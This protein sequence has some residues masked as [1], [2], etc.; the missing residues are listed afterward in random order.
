M[1]TRYRFILFIVLWVMLLTPACEKSNDGD[2][3]TIYKVVMLASGTTFDDMAFLQSCKEV[4]E[5]AHDEFNIS[6]AYDI[7]TS[8]TNYL[9]RINAYVDEGHDLIIAIGFMWNDAVVEAASS[10]PH[11]DFVLVDTE[12]SVTKD[13]V[14][15][16]LFDVDEAAFPLGFLSAWWADSHSTEPA[17][18][19]VGAM[20]IPQIRQFVEPY[21]SGAHYY[22]TKYDRLVDTMGV[23]ASTFF[24]R[25]LGKKLADSLIDEGTDV[26][27]GVGSETGLGAL[28][29]AKE[30]QKQAIGVDVDQ[31]YSFPEVSETLLSSAMKRLDIAI[32]NVIYL[33]MIDDFPG[34]KVYYAKMENN[35]VSVAPFHDYEQLIADSIKL[36]IQHISSGIIDGSIST[37]WND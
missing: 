17:I 14:V 22:N 6:V 30:R 34:G 35:G 33:F 1:H 19:S 18:G 36:E 9:Q 15:S 24:D 2:V 31:Y 28:L 37:G 21:Y 25:E 29:E 3:E 32:Y 5:K 8:T 12:L 26:I 11:I 20:R 10:Y 4:L 27:F 7:D 13:N 16:V 23:Y